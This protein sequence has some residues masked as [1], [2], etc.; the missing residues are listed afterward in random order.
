MVQIND[1]KK[2]VTIY[3]IAEILKMSPSTVSRALNDHPSIAKNTKKKVLE[4]AEKL[5][6]RF[7]K[8]A[9]N[10][11]QQKT[12]VIGV[13]IPRLDSYFM[14]TVIA[15]MENSAKNYGYNIIITQSNENVEKEKVCIEMLYNSRVDGILI[16]FSA[17]T[18]DLN[19]LEFILKKNIPIIVFDRYLDCNEITSVVIDNRKA[20]YDLV[21]HLIKEGCRNIVHVTENLTCSVYKERFEGYRD[22]LN[23][24]K[25]DFDEKLVFENSLFCSSYESFCD[26]ILS[27]KPRPDAIFASNDYAA[28]HILLELKKRNVNIPNEIAIAGFNDDPIASVV[29]PN[30]TTV[31]YSGMQIGEIAT[32]TLIERINGQ[33]RPTVNKIIL[34]HKLIIRKSTIKN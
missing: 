12:Y 18:K 13:V 8:F 31:K 2:E 32:R 23:E 14:S 19:H 15:G 27:F 28:V 5:G 11:R 20:S 6:Y 26:K 33:F 30:L 25:I 16:S 29:E 3:D 9:R 17:N 7:N 21:N 10:L 1:N 4:T 34:S 22:A 24:N